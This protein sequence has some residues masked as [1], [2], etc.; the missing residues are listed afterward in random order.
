[1]TSIIRSVATKSRTADPTRKTAFVAGVLYLIT[2]IAS[3]PAALLLDSVLHDPGYILNAGADSQVRLATVLDLVNALAAIGTAVALFSL[4]KREH[5]GLA[6]GFVTT[7]LFEAAVIVIGIVSILAVE[8]LRQTGATGADPSTLVTV[9]QSLVAVRDWTFVLGPGMAGFNALMLATL[10]YRARLVPR[11]IPA[12]GLVGAPL[13]IS[14]VAG[15]MLGLTE[16]GSTW[17]SVAVAPIFIWELSLGLWM[18]FKGFNRSAPLV[19]GSASHAA[20]PYGAPPATVPSHAPV[21]TKA[22]AA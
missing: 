2:F 6:L 16:L 7:R 19:A 3:I 21:A 22:G 13:Y 8:T 4:V 10:M 11:G 9:G 20:T 18:T 1:V 17:H 5:E 15:C 14:F 12:L